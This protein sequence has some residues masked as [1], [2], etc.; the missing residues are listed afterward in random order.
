MSFITITC[1]C[2]IDVYLF[3]LFFANYFDKRK[4]VASHILLE[5]ALQV[6]AV[7]F[8]ILC[9]YIGNGD[10]NIVVTPLVLFLYTTVLFGGKVGNKLLSFATVF[11]VLYGCEFLFM[12]IFR[13]NASDYKNSII[14]MLQ[15]MVI[16]FLSY[17]IILT[18]NQVIGKRKK[19]QDTRVFLMYMLIP[20]SSLMVMLTTYYATLNGE[21][22]LKVRIPF[23][24]GFVFL[25]IGNIV[26]FYAFESYSEYLHRNLQQKIVI[27]KQKKD[28]DHYMQ[29]AEIDKEQKELIH[30]IS[31]QMKMISYFANQ[32]DYKAV[33]KISGEINEEM[34]QDV[35]TVFCDNAVL[36]SIL[37]EKKREAEQQKISIELYVE[38][39]IVLNISVTEMITLFGNLLDNAIRAA[40]EAM[41]EKYIK[42]FIY[43]QEAG[44]FCVVKIVNS[45]HEVVLDQ[46][47]FLSTK[48]DKG[49]HGIGIRS[50]NRIAE[51]YG[52]YLNCSVKDDAFEAVLLLST[53]KN[54]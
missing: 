14:I 30:N 23:V 4:A 38:P 37:N 46:G 2:I 26:S 11:C 20:V 25:F 7:L 33:L 6:L 9:N 35:K 19:I 24:L 52:G 22:T 50:V 43:M 3:H 54:E 13:P 49:I 5:R 28:L 53:D 40:S 10:K 12:I 47:R 8:L 48:M 17:I 36:N 16:K 27:I 32:Q 18:I 29:I 21:L 45:F 39:G 51:K 41:G 44:G 15:V 42:V 31:N 1:S 34:Q